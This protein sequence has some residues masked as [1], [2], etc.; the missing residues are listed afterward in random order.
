[1]DWL[2]HLRDVCLQRLSH[3]KAAS[4]AWPYYPHAEP[5]TEAT[6]FATLALV[7]HGL[8]SELWE[9]SWK[10]VVTLQNPDGSIGVG[11]HARREGLWLTA[12]LLIVAVQ[13]SDKAV[14][15][16]ATRFL[17]AFQSKAMPQNPQVQQNNSIIGW[18]WSADTFGWVEPTAWAVLALQAA[19]QGACSRAVEGRRLLLDRMLPSGGWN[20]GNRVVHDQELLPFADTTALALLALHGNSTLDTLKPSIDLLDSTFPGHPS[21]YSY[22][23]LSMT[24]RLYGKPREQYQQ[25]LGDMLV[26]QSLEETN[27]AHLAL[28]I[29]SYAERNPFISS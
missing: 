5:S 23:W 11:P 28:C 29:I 27:M 25:S 15:D 9:P 7:V 16:R 10:W 26:S 20:Y 19:G 13:V 8:P 24:A 18:P 6:L 14:A 17:E 12:L 1:V 2:P 4:H 22:A 21:P 3:V